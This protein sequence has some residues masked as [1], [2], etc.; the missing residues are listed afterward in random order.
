MRAQA[1]GI[2]LTE[3]YA[4]VSTLKDG[5]V[6]HNH[7]YLDQDEALDAAGLRGSDRAP[8]AQR[9]GRLGSSSH[10]RVPN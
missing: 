6:I 5:K 1:S 4:G 3:T 7:D 10:A 9:G 8:Q 2:P